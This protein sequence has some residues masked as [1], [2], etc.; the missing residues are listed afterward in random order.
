MHMMDAHLHIVGFMEAYRKEHGLQEYEPVP[1]LHIAECLN[2]KETFVRRHLK[3][4][5]NT[6][7]WPIV[8]RICLKFSSKTVPLRAARLDTFIAGLDMRNVR[9]LFV[10]RLCIC[11]MMRYRNME[12]ALDGCSTV[13][14]DLETV[15]GMNAVPGAAGGPQLS[16]MMNTSMRMSVVPGEGYAVGRRS[17]YRVRG[18][19]MM[20]SEAPALDP[21]LGKPAEVAATFAVNSILQDMRIGMSGWLEEVQ[22]DVVE[23]LKALQRSMAQQRKKTRAATGSFT[24]MMNVYEYCAECARELSEEQKSVSFTNIASTYSLS[25]HDVRNAYEFLSV[26]ELREQVQKLFDTFLAARGPKAPD[27]F[28]ISQFRAFS[29]ALRSIM[30]GTRLSPTSEWD[31]DLSGLIH[32]V[33]PVFRRISDEGSWSEAL[34]LGS[35]LFSSPRTDSMTSLDVVSVSLPSAA[36]AYPRNNRDPKL[37]RKRG[38]KRGGLK[39][40]TV[41]PR[42]ASIASV[43]LPSPAVHAGSSQL[44]LDVVDMVDVYVEQVADFTRSAR[45]HPSVEDIADAMMLPISDIEA[46]TMLAPHLRKGD[47]SNFRANFLNVLRDYRETSVLPNVQDVISLSSFFFIFLTLDLNDPADMELVRK[48]LIAMLGST[49]IKAGSVLARNIKKEEL[50]RRAAE[51]RRHEQ[52]LM[53]EHVAA[54]SVSYGSTTDVP[55]DSM[56]QPDAAFDNL[57]EN[58]LQQEVTLVPSS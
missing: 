10:L 24:S 3:L 53:S 51:Q 23:E 20:S 2:V 30:A 11:E 37:K 46:L 13:R 48:C 25:V 50:A 31:Q 39:V 36:P 56:P 14:R 35:S 33:L 43:E 27:V 16:V 1:T 26:V 4:L 12:L 57:L 29:N 19:S 42:K 54:D 32:V 49:S 15:L 55:D 7:M 28:N 44:C 52:S 22:A 40:E 38:R 9:D 18:K 58:I 41:G 17:S 6:W 8:K 45:R 21:V 34:A 5:S 47:P